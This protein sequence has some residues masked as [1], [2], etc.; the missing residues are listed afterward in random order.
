MDRTDA[1][2]PDHAALHARAR[3][4]GVNL[5]V[6]RIVRLVL[7]PFFTLYFR[8]DR[9]GREHIPAEGG[10]IIA[11]NHRSFL[12][13]FIIGACASRPLYF[14]AK[15]ELF[16]RPWQAWILNALGAFPVDRGNADEETITTARAILARGDIVLIFPE[17]TR[18]RPGTLGRPRRG[19]GRL[20]LEAGVPVIPIAVTGTE[21]V[22]RGWRIRPHKVRVRAGRPL[23]FPQVDHAS[24]QLAAAV[25][26]RIWP[27]V[28]L[29]WEW[30]GGLA[31]IRRACVIGTGRWGTFL[32]VSLA[33]A[34]YDV[35][36]GC[37]SD[38]RARLIAET[39]E[40]PRFPGL[41]LPEK[42]NVVAADRLDLYGHDLVC[43]AVPAGALPT[44]LDAHEGQ[45]PTSTGVLV[46]SR[47]HVGPHGHSAAAYVGERCRAR[48]LAVAA[49]EAVEGD[50]R[51][52]AEVASTDRG[53]TRQIADVLR[54]LG[55]DV[56]TQADVA[57]L[58]RRLSG[59][60]MPAS[61]A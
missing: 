51:V 1:H 42:V 26:N 8:L 3:E 5:L 60:A 2:A 30:L 58:E 33:R 4:K 27:C 59:D 53:F 36:L 39:R 46:L 50:E 34:G 16:A 24:P 52:H 6:Y 40:S 44:V 25:T 61:V 15:K 45:I 21:A 17:G 55:M 31:P 38:E 13:P 12:D 37:S 47:G 41:E 57:G 9:L 56:A 29:Q 20:A 19:V 14:V 22:R 10:A 54:D 49:L 35:D 32:A 7:V 18:I 48:A 23:H 28:A 11:A 43:L